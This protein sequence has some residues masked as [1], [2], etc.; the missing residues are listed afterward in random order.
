M[1]IFLKHFGLSKSEIFKPF[2][3][4]LDQAQCVLRGFTDC[5]EYTFPT[6]DCSCVV[7]LRGVDNPTEYLRRILYIL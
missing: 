4:M 3:R 7:P 1:D 6:E 2:S 5:E